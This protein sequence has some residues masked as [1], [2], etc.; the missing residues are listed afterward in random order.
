MARNR[1]APPKPMNPLK[2]KP[3][4]RVMLLN[5]ARMRKWDYVYALID[6][7]EAG[8]DDFLHVRC[9]ML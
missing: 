3:V 9:H 4:R 6:N 1:R 5:L 7:G 2:R 8:I